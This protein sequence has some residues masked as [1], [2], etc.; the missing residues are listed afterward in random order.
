MQGRAGV[1]PGPLYTSWGGGLRYEADLCVSDRADI[2]AL[3]YLFGDRRL[4][5]L[6]RHVWS[7]AL[8]RA[9]GVAR[10]EVAHSRLL[11]ALLDPRR[12]QSATVML[13]VMLQ[14]IVNHPR[15]EQT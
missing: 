8:I 14:G 11:A 15:L 5:D 6:D 2:E 9:I 3:R 4:K 10:D 7:L 13:R 12:N 1:S